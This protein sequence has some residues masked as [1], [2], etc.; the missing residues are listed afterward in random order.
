M[1]VTLINPQ[2]S[3]FNRSEKVLSHCL[4]LLY[5]ASYLRSKGH[6]IT[7]IDS[8]QEGF[9][10]EEILETGIIKVGLSNENIIKRI[11]GDTDI[12]GIGV[13]FS[14][15]APST[16]ALTKDIKDRLPHIPLVMGGVYPSSQ[17]ELAITSEAD[18]LVIGEGEY[19]MEKLIE[20]VRNNMEGE[21]PP[22]IIPKRDPS[23]LNKAKREVIKDVDALPFPAR[24]LIPFE[25]Y[26]GRSQR[27]VRGWRSASIITSRGCPYDCEFCSIHAV[28]S[29]VWRTR[30]P[31]NVLAEIDS[32]VDTYGINNIEFED[33]MLTLKRDRIVKIM[34]GIIERNKNGKEI[35]WQAL[36]GIR[37]DTLDEDLLLKF[38]EAN[39]R[40]IN[41]AL[42]SGDEDVQ[43]LINKKLDLGKVK[44][45]MALVEKHK[46]P[47]HIFVI[48][49]YPGETKE[50]F[51]NSV[52]FYKE[53]KAI[54]PSAQFKFFIAQPY[55]NTKLFERAVRLGYLPAD[56]FDQLDAFTQFSTS[57]Q[58]WLETEDFDKKEVLRRR[59]EL[60][61]SVFSTSEYLIQRIRDSFPDPIVDFLYSLYYFRERVMKKFA[62]E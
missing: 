35:Y 28:A 51:D 34:D 2:F 41:L 43:K 39:V 31:E 27:N 20:Y 6:D 13:S 5:I 12:T 4:G 14:H 30:S 25:K 45:I 42:E 44:E 24:D 50:R 19:T 7:F 60:F 29:R 57:S 59:K 21:L 23:Y 49:G 16:H 11:P 47:T 46:I 61:R 40:H 15:M 10:H 54:A 8:L 38:K 48:F 18:F 32:L 53:I 17:P 26:V 55:P 36:N 3:F 33:D 62:V 52:Q 58:V 37:F 9:D 56:L 1:K 22:A